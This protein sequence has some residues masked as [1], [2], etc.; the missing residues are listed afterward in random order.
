MGTIVPRPR[1][2][3]TTAYMAQIAIMR[4]GRSHRESKTFD[5]EPAARAWVKKREAELAKP[6]AL[7]AAASPTRN[8]T[9]GEAIGRYERESK[10]AFGRTKTQVMRALKADPIAETICS[11]LTSQDIVGLASRLAERRSPATVANYLSHLSPVFTIAR[12]GW[13]IPL[14]EGAMTDGVTVAK[15]L[16]LTGKSKQRDRRPTMGEL[17][18]ILEHFEASRRKRPGAMPMA[19]IVAFALFSARREE[20]ITLIR[21]DDLDVEGKRVLVRDMKDPEN[22][23]G[24]NVWCELPDEALRIARAQP[25]TS[26]E[27][28]PYNHRTISANMTRAA[29]FLQIDDLHFHDLRHEGISRLFEMGRTIPQAASISGHRSWATMKRYAHLRQVGDKYAGWPWLDRLAPQR[30]PDDSTTGTN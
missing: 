9:L 8:I 10:K 19:A 3:G 20:E 1:K 24:N 12:P 21:W 11:E 17:D 22:K 25:R 7:A 2:D 30:A 23:A 4:E 15:K 16:G 14:A 13:G 6:G 27:I 29:A 28:F 5:R 18:R 26:R